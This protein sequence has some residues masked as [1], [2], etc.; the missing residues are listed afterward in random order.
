[1]LTS[2]VAVVK[3]HHSISVKF[4]RYPGTGPTDPSPIN[5]RLFILFKI[6]VN[7]LVS[8]DA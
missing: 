6:E 8:S 4:S 5:N 1:M 7:L 2:E 3:S